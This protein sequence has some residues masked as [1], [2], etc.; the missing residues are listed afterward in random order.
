M[1]NFS[2]SQKQIEKRSDLFNLIQAK[3]P[4]LIDELAV[5]TDVS[6]STLRR[7]LRKLMDDGLVHIN[8]GQVTIS[9]TAKE[10]LPFAYRI[11]QNHEEK[12]SIAQAALELIKNGET[13]AITGGTTTLELARL[14]PGKRR[15]TVITNALPVANVLVEDRNIKTILLGGEIRPGELSMHGHLVMSGIEQLRADKLFYGIE[16]IS[17]EFGLTHSQLV[18]VNTD[19]ALIK[20]FGQT[21]ILADHFKFGKVAPAIVVPIDKVD[22]IITGKELDKNHIEK[23]KKH[24]VRL[25]LV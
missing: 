5:L 21:I 22:T 8:S 13:I 20:A 10:E 24:D 6:S 18:E 15:V 11:T 4:I 3:E 19:R 7:I 17:P 14:L 25:I 16:A 12:M 1:E 2:D 23:I 9:K